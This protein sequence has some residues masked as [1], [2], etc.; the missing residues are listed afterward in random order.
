LL[1]EPVGIE[2]A[3]AVDHIARSIARDLLPE[4]AV[5]AS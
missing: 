1:A 4:I 2:A 3:I 5:K